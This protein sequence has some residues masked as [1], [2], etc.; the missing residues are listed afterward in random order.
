MVRHPAPYGP[1]LRRDEAIAAAGGAGRGPCGVRFRAIIRPMQDAQ[2]L[3]SRNTAG[4]NSL[5]DLRRDLQ[6]PPDVARSSLPI[7]LGRI[8]E[9]Q[10]GQAVIRDGAADSPRE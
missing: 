2:E 9:D 7:L 10:V 3:C 1:E 4:Q 6:S 5:V 8:V